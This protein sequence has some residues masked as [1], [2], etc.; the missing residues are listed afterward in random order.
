MVWRLVPSAGE[1][2]LCDPALLRLQGCYRSTIQGLLPCLGGAGSSSP[3]HAAEASSPEHSVLQNPSKFILDEVWCL[4]GVG[5]PATED[6]CFSIARGSDSALIQS[7]SSQ[8][9]Q[10]VL[11]RAHRASPA[12]LHQTD[13]GYSACGELNQGDMCCGRSQRLNSGPV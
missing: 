8:H 1:H 10:P 12:T 6:G 3:A 7:W 4:R 2:W 9:H 11:C 5:V 13:T